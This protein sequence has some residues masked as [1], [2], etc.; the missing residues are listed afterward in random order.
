[1]KPSDVLRHNAENCLQLAARAEGLPA[2]RRYL[3][4][5]QAWTAL[6]H[7]QAWLDGETSPLAVGAQ[8]FEWREGRALVGIRR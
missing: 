7:E 2:M 6:A 3:R 8:S 5:A 1:M 4:M